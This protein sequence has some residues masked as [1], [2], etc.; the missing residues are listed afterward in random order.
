MGPLASHAARATWMSNFLAAG[1]IEAASSPPVLQ[2]A[3]A[4]RAFVESGADVACLCGTDETYAEMGEAMASLIKTAGASHLV[5]AGRP[6][7][8][9][10]G[11]I[12]AG[13]DGFVYAGCDMIA[14]LTA[15]QTALDVAPPAAG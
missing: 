15:L 11:L 9:E 6:K 8:L 4:G 14:T 12:A 5:L 1:G 7:E 10:A 2:S 3:D 13:V